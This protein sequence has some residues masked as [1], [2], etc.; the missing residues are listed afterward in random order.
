MERNV[1]INIKDLLAKYNISLREL[2]RRTDI[3]HAALN[4]LA[5]N[6]REFVYLNHLK[7]IADA[8]DIDD[9]NEIIYFESSNRE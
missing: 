7:K 1:V 6:E 4:E 5:N 8:L 3:R 9:M 2:S